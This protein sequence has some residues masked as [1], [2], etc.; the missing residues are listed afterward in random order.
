MSVSSPGP[1]ICLDKL[2][3]ALKI[4]ASPISIYFPCI[5]QTTIMV[6]TS[7]LYPRPQHHAHQG[8]GGRLPDRGGAAAVPPLRSLPRPGDQSP[9]M[10]RVQ[11]CSEKLLCSFTVEPLLHTFCLRSIP[12]YPNVVHMC[13][14]QLVSQLVTLVQNLTN[15]L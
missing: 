14:S 4:F 15:L 8:A 6:A 11:T 10:Q 2:V 9:D 13:V 7:S 12:I 3:L 5:V 1:L